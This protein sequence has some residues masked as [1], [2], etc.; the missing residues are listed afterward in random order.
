MVKKSQ[1]PELPT[2]TDFLP[3]LSAMICIFAYCFNNQL[4]TCKFDILMCIKEFV[5]HQQGETKLK[6]IVYRRS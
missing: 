2:N 5:G 3:I 4:P 1:N 6:C